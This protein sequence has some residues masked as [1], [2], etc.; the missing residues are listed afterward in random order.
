LRVLEI[1]DINEFL[2]AGGVI[3]FPTDTVWGLGVLPQ[4]V[5]KLF[6]I[7]QRPASKSVIVMS[8]KIEN[9]RPHMELAIYSDRAIELMKKYFPGALTIVGEKDIG[10]VRI[11][12]N[13]ALLKLCSE[14]DGHCLATSSANISGQSVC[15]S[16]KEVAQVFPTVRIVGDGQP[17]GLASTVI[18]VIGNAITILRQGEVEVNEELKIKN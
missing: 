3:A 9:L 17:S 7:K 12:D 16:A 11:P 6:E 18:K 14:I 5:E 8:D 1:N 13:E 4:F 10:G 15:G 2:K